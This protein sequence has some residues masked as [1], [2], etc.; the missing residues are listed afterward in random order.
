MNTQHARPTRV[1]IELDAEAV[2]ALD[3]ARRDERL[4]RPNHVRAVLARALRQTGHLA[5]T[6]ETAR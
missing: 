5:S 1:V 2:R 4:S 6:V 3:A